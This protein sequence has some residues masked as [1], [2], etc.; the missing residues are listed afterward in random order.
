MIVFFRNRWT[1][2]SKLLKK[3]EEIMVPTAAGH[4]SKP[5]DDDL[6]VDELWE[7]ATLEK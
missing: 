6:E 5:N 1:K 4:K 7:V 3:K 2:V